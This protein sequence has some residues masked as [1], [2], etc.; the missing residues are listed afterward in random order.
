MWNSK[1]LTINLGSFAW[2]VSEHIFHLP[3]INVDI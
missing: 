1:S 3:Y 2:D